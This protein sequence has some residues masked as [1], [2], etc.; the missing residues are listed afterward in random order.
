MGIGSSHT[1]GDAA[2]EIDSKE[3]C[4]NGSNGTSAAA[5]PAVEDKIYFCA[6]SAK[7]IVL[8]RT[9]DRQQG[10]PNPKTTIKHM[11]LTLMHSMSEEYHWIRLIVVLSVIDATNATKRG[12]SWCMLVSFRRDYVQSADLFF[13]R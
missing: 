3:A 12:P 13:A 10:Q 7:S 9:T 5:S 2:Y 1:A 4:N 8:E 6:G 11:K